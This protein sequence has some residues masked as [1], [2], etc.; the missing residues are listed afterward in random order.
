[1][2]TDQQSPAARLENLASLTQDVDNDNPSAEQRQAEQK[3]AEQA[4]AAEQGAKDW[5][6]L[7]YTVG[8]FACMIAPELKPVYS[9]DRCLTWGAHAN[10][11]AEKYGWNGMTAMPELALIACTVTFAA[12]TWMLVRARLQDLKDSKE[13]TWLEKMG[14]WWR[15]RKAGKAAPADT[16]AT[17][18]SK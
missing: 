10:Q 5:G 13:G 8:G 3:Q 9:Q 6:M 7:M 18:G 15:N 12:P 16:A 11:V 4:T 1:M 2:T 17:D 14:A